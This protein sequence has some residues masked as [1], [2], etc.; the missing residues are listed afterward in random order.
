MVNSWKV[1]LATLVI[2][3]TGLMAGRWLVVKEPVK[4]TKPVRPA[5][6]VTNAPAPRLVLSRLELLRRMKQS[7]ALS[8]DQHERVDKIIAESQERVKALWEI[9][10][11]EMQD[12][13]QRVRVLIAGELDA[14]QKTKFEKMIS[15]SDRSPKGKALPRRPVEER[16][17][18]KGATV[19]K[20][21][22][23]PRILPK[24]SSPLNEPPAAPPPTSPGP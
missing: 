6:A 24:D 23:P 11:P 22:S 13:L 3:G 7:L 14:E 12:E 16:E 17:S 1:I 9:I 15:D 20:R 8:R 4:V 10:A 21:G 5:T 18:G 2:F 19:P